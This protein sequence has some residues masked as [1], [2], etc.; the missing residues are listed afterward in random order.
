MYGQMLLTSVDA[1]DSWGLRDVWL[2]T[3][4]E[5]E[6]DIEHLAYFLKHEAR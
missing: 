4:A 2:Q 5:P 6:R 1:A 3:I